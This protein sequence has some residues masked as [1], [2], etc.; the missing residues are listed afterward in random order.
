MAKFKAVLPAPE[1]LEE[2]QLDE[3]PPWGDSWLLVLF[4]NYLFRFDA[5]FNFLIKLLLGLFNCSLPM[6][7]KICILLLNFYIFEKYYL[8]ITD[9]V[10]NGDWLYEVAKFDDPTGLLGS[11]AAT[12]G[13]LLLCGFI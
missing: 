11:G 2:K 8:F 6:G 4:L 12:A 10:N 3:V 13:G 1:T 9:L 7:F 5:F